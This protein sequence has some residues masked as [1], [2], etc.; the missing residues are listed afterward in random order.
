[1]K[2]SSRKNKQHGRELTRNSTEIFS[3]EEE[4]LGVGVVR[5]K[6]KA[7]RRR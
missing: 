3:K 7:A 2:K 6:S 5:G 1:M 4:A